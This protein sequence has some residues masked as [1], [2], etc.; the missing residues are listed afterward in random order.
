MCLTISST[1]LIGCSKTLTDATN[2]GEAIGRLA[3]TRD[4]PTYP[5]DCRE[6]VPRKTRKGD[7]FDVAYL[8]S[9]SSRQ[10]LNAQV[11]RC[12]DWYDTLR[13]EYARR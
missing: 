7:R 9:D 11:L 4:L 6:T 10:T 12:A 5:K 13:K 2:N 1:T 8:K 3:A